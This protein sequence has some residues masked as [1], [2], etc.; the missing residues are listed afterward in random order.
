MREMDRRTFLLSTGRWL[1]IAALAPTASGCARLLRWSD[2][3]GGLNDSDVASSD[4]TVSS[5]TTTDGA[6]STTT[7]TL[8][9]PHRQ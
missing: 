1:A 5:T 9:T 2:S 4:E 6:E 8:P 3:Q 7:T